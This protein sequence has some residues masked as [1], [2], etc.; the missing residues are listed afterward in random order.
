MYKLWRRKKL[1]YNKIYAID[2]CNIEVKFIDTKREI[3]GT[4]KNLL[5]QNICLIQLRYIE[6]LLNFKNLSFIY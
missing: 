4:F 5:Y 1:Y 3:F 6:V 2:L